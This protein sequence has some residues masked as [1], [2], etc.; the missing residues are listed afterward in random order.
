[1]GKKEWE[2]TQFF[3]GGAPPQS[4]GMFDRDDAEKIIYHFHPYTYHIHAS[5]CDLE[6]IH[7]LFCEDD[8]MVEMESKDYWQ[9]MGGSLN[10]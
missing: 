2:V 4:V 8:G 9:R 1:M 6:G 3:F 5:H 7:Y 10:S